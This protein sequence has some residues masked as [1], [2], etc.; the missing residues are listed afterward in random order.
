MP[1]KVTC[2]PDPSGLPAGAASKATDQAISLTQE[3]LEAVAVLFAAI[4]TL[5]SQNHEANIESMTIAFDA[6]VHSVLGRLNERIAAM[7]GDKYR[8]QAE[9]VMAKHGLFD[10]CFQEVI[11]HATSINPQLGAVIRKLRLVH[12]SLLQSFPPLLAASRAKNDEDINILKEQAEQ[13]EGETSQLLVA[14][15]MMEKELQEQQHEIQRLRAELARATEENDTLKSTYYR[16]PEK[17]VGNSKTVKEVAVT[18][19]VG[20]S[21]RRSG[22]QETFKG[23]SSEDDNSTAQAV[24][25]R[26][27]TLKQLKEFIYLIYASKERHDKKSLLARLPK[28]TMEQHMYTFLN[29]R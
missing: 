11:H 21:T 17:I 10:V 2:I 15:E 23:T 19:E 18:K 5:R 14:A 7:K 1:E 12:T 24:V 26:N 27:L 8:K 13:S 29:Q 16:R 28:E 22:G 25:V 20:G 3:D 4:K 9:I 6:H